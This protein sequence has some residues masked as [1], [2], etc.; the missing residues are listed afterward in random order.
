MR[1]RVATALPFVL[2]WLLGLLVSAAHNWELGPT[3]AAVA[4]PY[5][6]AIG[7]G[8]PWISAEI[9]ILYLVVWP[10]TFRLRIGRLCWAL[11]LLVPWT[12]LV[13]SVIWKYGWYNGWHFAHAYWLLLLTTVVFAALL[14]TLLRPS[15]KV[16]TP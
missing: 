10:K 8:L 3:D 9:V 7:R 11:A 6:E 12:A 15:P 14:A 13:A 4:I 16:S 5:L 2:L 1:V